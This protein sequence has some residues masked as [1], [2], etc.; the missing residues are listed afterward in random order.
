MGLYVLGNS[1]T[2]IANL[3]H[4]ATVVT[5]GPDSKLALSMHRVNHIVNKFGPDLWWNPQ[6]SR[7]SAADVYLYAVTLGTCAMTTQDS[8]LHCGPARGMVVTTSRQADE[9]SALF[10]D[11]ER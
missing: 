6:L 2:V 11:E 8:T 7:R 9:Q 4:D 3:N 1:W 10:V 5:V